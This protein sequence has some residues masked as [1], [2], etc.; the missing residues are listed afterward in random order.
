MGLKGEIDVFKIVR[1]SAFG[2]MGRHS[3]VDVDMAE[4]LD[5]RERQDWTVP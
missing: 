4:E 5:R 3:A 1:N 2:D